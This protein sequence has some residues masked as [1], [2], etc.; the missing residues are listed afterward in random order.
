VANPLETSDFVT[1]LGILRI[2]AAAAEPAP[3]DSRTLRPR[4]RLMSVYSTRTRRAR[5]GFVEPCQPTT[6]PSPPEGPEWLHE[7]KHDGYRLMAR[8][9]GADIQLITRGRHDWSDRYPAIAQAL[10][11]LFVTSCM[12]DGEVVIAD[13]DGIPSFDLLRTGS[14]VKPDAILC[15]F[16]LIELNGQ[17][18]R[19]LP[20]ER[21][22]SYLER[23]VRKSG[24]DISYVDHVFGD[25][26]A[27]FQQVCS[28]GLEG[29]VS[30]RKGSTYRSGRSLDWRKSKNPNSPAVRREAEEDWSR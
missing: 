12:L 9:D 25:G 27:V 17:D 6:T 4:I 8:R 18:V 28:L 10:R 15:A 3:L 30:K 29:I 21:R 11:E 24:P 22:K 1:W 2:C 13:A 23:L 16:D 20:I 5:P 7:I 14:W 19:R 26:P